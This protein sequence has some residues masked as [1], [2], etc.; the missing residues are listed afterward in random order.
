MEPN[1]Q[2]CNIKETPM[3]E[4]VASPTQLQFCLYKRYTLPLY[5]LYC[6]LRFA[7]HCECPKNRFIKTPDWKP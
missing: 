7:C 5:C 3:S 6:Q 2:L 4:L 1:Y